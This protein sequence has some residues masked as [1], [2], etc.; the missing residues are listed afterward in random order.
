[1]D[2]ILT[3]A[4]LAAVLFAPA[5]A[6]PPSPIAPARIIDMHVHAYARDERWQARIGNP[7]TGQTMVA[8][9]ENAHREATFAAMKRAHVVKA[10]ISGDYEAVLRWKQA[11][12]DQVIVGYSFDDPE[13][14][15]LGFLR[16][17]KAAGRL[18][19]LGEVGS[20]YEGIGPNDPKMEPIYA[21]AEELDLPLG[22]HMH[23]G[24]PG[25]TA[26]GYPK[27]RPALGDPLLLE[28]VLVRHPRLRLYVM[29]AG[30]PFLEN[31]IALLNAY[32]QVYVDV[33]VID[34][35]KPR[36]E[37][38]RYLR[39][40]VEAGYGKRIMFGSDQMVWPEAIEMAVAAIQS[41]D[42][43]TAGQK[44]DIFYHNAARFLRLEPTTPVAPK[45]A[46]ETL[47]R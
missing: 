24:P 35:T 17:E 43:L 33:G 39:G 11:A 38:D 9:D 23:P 30:W 5:P 27:I 20:Q 32:P 45:G 36:K 46:M 3:S 21:L 13:K 42:Y 12:P 2:S 22:L 41:A 40:L 44:S 34:W 1:M 8:T 6:A 4:F 10:M 16:Q 47:P 26:I 28:D 37:F 18:D 14:V 31:M 29:H 15:D 7:V 25:A 19:A